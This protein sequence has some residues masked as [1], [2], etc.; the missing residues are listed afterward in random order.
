MA[1]RSPGSEDE[2]RIVAK[3]KIT[4]NAGG[5]YITS[6]RAASRSGTLG[7]YLIKS[8]Y[9]EALGPASQKAAGP[10]VPTKPVQTSTAVQRA[11]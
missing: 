7:D 11:A 3:K 8:A 6:M 9:F 4:L 10:G 2:I 1:W 5:S